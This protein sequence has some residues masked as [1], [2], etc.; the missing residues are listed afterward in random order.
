[1]GIVEERRS[2]SAAMATRI[3]VLSR[4]MS[5]S[6]RRRYAVRRLPTAWANTCDCPSGSPCIA[7]SAMK[8]RL[9][10]PDPMILFRSTS[11]ALRPFVSSFFRSALFPSVNASRTS[12]RSSSLMKSP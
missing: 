8:S 5:D 3:S 6:L 11:V 2:T 9:A 12:C 4:A 1:M 7:L 10:T